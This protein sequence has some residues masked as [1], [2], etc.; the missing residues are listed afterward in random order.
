M[1]AVTIAPS[2]VRHHSSLRRRKRPF[3]LPSAPPTAFSVGAAAE[4]R[5][6][7]G[8]RGARAG[9]GSVAVD[10]VRPPDEARGRFA[11]A[12]F[13]PES[14]RK[15]PSVGAGLRPVPPPA[16]AARGTAARRDGLPRASPRRPRRGSV[17]AGRRRPR[18]RQTRRGRPQGPRVTGACVV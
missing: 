11:S 5:G 14:G 8:L 6:G 2:K 3:F 17:P 12:P 1:A 4:A 18:A 13:P 10:R 7:A 15:R 9:P 16:A